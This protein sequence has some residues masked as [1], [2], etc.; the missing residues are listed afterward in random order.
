[1]GFSSDNEYT[2]PSQPPLPLSPKKKKKKQ[3]ETK[4]ILWTMPR[5]YGVESENEF[6]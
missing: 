6:W 1:M 3:T 4:N 5:A 2:A